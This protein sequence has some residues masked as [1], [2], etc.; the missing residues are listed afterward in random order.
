MYKKNISL[1]KKLN[2]KNIL[3]LDKNYETPIWIYDL[4]IIIQQIKKLKKFD[5]IRFAQKACSNLN[6]LKIMKK[7]KI[8]V[9][10]VSLGE[11]ERALLSGFKPKTND[12]IYTSDILEEKTLKYIIKY[13]IPVNAGSICM[14]EQLGKKSPKHPVWL[15]I[16]PKFGAG[17]HI[18]TNTGG[19]NSK[20]GIWDPKKALLIIKKYN[21]KLIGLHMHIG[22]G[23][24]YNHLKK[25]ST[26]MIQYALKI[27]QKIKFISAGGGLSIPY[28]NN[29]E[30]INIYE[31]YKIWN[32]ARK[33]IESKLKC[34]IKL[35]IEPGR[36]LTAQSGVLV[37]KVCAVKKSGKNNF[38]ILNA[39]F[40]DLIRPVLYNS[41]H[42]ITV[43]T[44]K[45]KNI[46][47]NKIHK[48]I[49]TGPLCESGD[50]FTVDSQGYIKKIKTR[51]IYQNDYIIIHD[52]GAYGSTMSSNY[53]SKPLIPELLYKNNDFILIRKKQTIKEMLSLEKCIL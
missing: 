9:D 38:V 40:N 25:V 36:F 21:L 20:H 52:T 48:N 39:G 47:K 30:E 13:K 34:S 15:R 43:I 2:Y 28:K 44:K 1:K 53:N 24:N 16:N 37:S 31:Y 3:Y 49:I 4:N 51:K 22:S 6:I 19:E 50:I 45:N 35:E 46:Q 12:I 32:K 7:N 41:Y 5:I 14:L 33:L 10:A 11:L 23:A 18:K 42:K 8:K 29:E 26:A 27:N 17:H